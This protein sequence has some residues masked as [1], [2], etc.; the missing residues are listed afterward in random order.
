MPTRCATASLAHS[1][2][3][4]P[5]SHPGGYLFT[6]NTVPTDDGTRACRRVSLAGKLAQYAGGTHPC[7]SG[8]CPRRPRSRPSPFPLRTMPADDGTRASRRV[9]LAGK[10]AQGLGWHGAPVRAGLA[11]EGRGRGRPR[12]RRA[13]CLPKT[14]HAPPGAFRLQAS[15][16]KGSG[17][18][19]PLCERASPA[20][21]AVAAVP[22]SF[23][24]RGSRRRDTRLPARFA[25]RQARTGL[26]WHGAPVRA[27]LAREGRGRGRPRLRRAP[28]QPTTGHAP[29]ARFAWHSKLAQ[30]VGSVFALL[31][32]RAFPRRPT[33]DCTA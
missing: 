24:H 18:T 10:L 11:R 13:P 25:C 21:A 31:P 7:A 20:K 4:W 14:G 1:G 32:C 22:V 28:G 29:P 8:P 5:Q 9:S 26:G 6:F 15:S 23:A 16:H 27:G 19:V 17:G 33:R 3:G 30:G 2:T 12:L